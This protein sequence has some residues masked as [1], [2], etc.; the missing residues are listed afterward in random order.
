AQRPA[1]ATGSVCWRRSAPV[2]CHR[3]EIRAMTDTRRIML[4]VIAALLPGSATMTWYFG[5]GVT[6][7]IV[8]AISLALLMEA[9]V[10]AARGQSFKPLT[11]GSAVITAWLLALAVTPLLP[12]WMLATGLFFAIVI[13][14]HLYGGLGHN[15]FNP[16]MV[17]FAV[18]IVSFPLQ[19]SQWPVAY[20]ELPF[21]QL[22]DY[23]LNNLAGWDGVTGATPLDEMKFRGAQTL[24]EFWR[25]GIEARHLNREAW[26]VVNLAFLLGGIALILLR[27]IDWRIPTAMLLTLGA[28]ALLFLDGGSSESLGSPI[29]HWLTGATMLG[30]FFIATDPVTSP[31][32]ARGLWIFGIGTALLTFIIRTLG[33]YPEGLAFAILLMNAA[34]PLI[35][36]IRWSRT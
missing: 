9:A 20:S 18:L 30:A 28:L 11:D 22:M 29:F 24:E 25:A 35:E 31:D 5:A 27:V 23:K 32:S 17:G 34:T 26:Q 21:A 1:K 33:A 15:T 6:L 4:L 3:Q 10:L 16:A 14:K 2:R 36:Q 19:M 8:V 12:F 7:N 13:A